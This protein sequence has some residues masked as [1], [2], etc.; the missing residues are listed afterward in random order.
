M[1]S[2]DLRTAVNSLKNNHAKLQKSYA[3]QDYQNMESF[4]T[5]GGTMANGTY[6][7]LDNLFQWAMLQTKQAYFTIEPIKLYAIVEQVAYNY[8]GLFQDKGITFSNQLHKNTVVYVD[9]ETIK[10]ILR[11]LIDNAIKYTD[12]GGFIKIY[13]SN[14]THGQCELVIE[15]SGQG[16]NLEALKLLSDDKGFSEARKNGYVKGSG[17]GLQL[18]RSMIYKNNGKFAI[19]SEVDKGTKITITLLNNQSELNG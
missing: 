9:Q 19:D 16:M 12:R 7:L 11:N 3:T 4:I 2:H 18:C 13:I 6:N 1:V 8:Q 5:S 14:E 10:I 15:D 17:L